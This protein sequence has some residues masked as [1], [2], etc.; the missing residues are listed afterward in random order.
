MIAAMTDDTIRAVFWDFGGVIL[1]SPFEAFNRYERSHDLP[2]DFIRGV[3]AAD[4]DANAWARLERNDITPHQ[5]DEAFADES[6]QRGHRVPGADVLALLSGDVRPE[7]VIALDHVIAAGLTTAC[8]TNNVVADNRSGP[9]HPLVADVMA[10]FDH[11]VESSKV[12]VRKP[13]PRFYEIA[14]ELA[15][16]R[17]ENCVFLDDLGINLKPA[18]AMGMRTIKV[19]SADEAIDDLAATL[20]LDLR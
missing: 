17:P 16:V 18:R 5:F 14:C 1:T 12:G 7:M 13:E 3:N 19:V 20:N 9:A 11:V 15:G 8:L 10:K 2:P 6:A 4:P